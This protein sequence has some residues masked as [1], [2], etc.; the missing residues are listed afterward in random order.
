MFKKD[1]SKILSVFHK[2]EAELEQF[3]DRVDKEKA[4][5]REK[6]AAIKTMIHERV[7]DIERATHV[8]KKIRQLVS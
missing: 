1:L 3:I 8:Q 6:E 2:A 4:A 5:L 7:D